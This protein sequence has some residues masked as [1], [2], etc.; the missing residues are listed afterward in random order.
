M[1]SHPAPPGDDAPGDHHR[2][3]RASA[4]DPPRAAARLLSWAGWLLAAASIV[5][6]AVL[7]A[8]LAALQE[9]A[10]VGDP[11][12]RRDR[13]VVEVPDVSVLDWTPLDHPAARGLAGR[14]TWSDA[15]N[16]GYMTFRGLAVNDPSV[17]QYQLWILRGT[18]LAAEPHPVDGGVYDVAADGEVVV[19][20]DP[21]LAVGRA[22]TF[23]VTVEA[24]GGEVVSDRAQ[25]VALAQRAL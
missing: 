23:L 5:L 3:E 25:V 10:R 2:D 1:A 22:G 6:C 21:K 9:E 11:S 24:P 19:A 18:D 13:L 7:A 16:E 14:I 20:V 15:R 4:D 17:S 12:V 8:R